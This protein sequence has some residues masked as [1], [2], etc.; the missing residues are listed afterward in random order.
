MRKSILVK[1]FVVMEKSIGE[2][3]IL[4]IFYIGLFKIVE[5]LLVEL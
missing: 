3:N 4:I 5:D 2:L 1:M